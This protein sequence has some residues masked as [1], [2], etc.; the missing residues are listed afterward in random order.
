MKELER[1]VAAIVIAAFDDAA[2]IDARFKLLDSFEGLL[3]RPIIKD[4]LAKKHNSL[5]HAYSLDLIQVQTIFHEFK[6]KPRISSN[7]PPVR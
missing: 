4:E 3:A 1:R 7:L 6:D 5:L 2:T